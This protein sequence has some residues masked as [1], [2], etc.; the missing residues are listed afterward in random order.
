MNQLNLQSLKVNYSN[1]EVY[2][3]DYFVDKSSLQ[4][5][6]KDAYRTDLNK[7]RFKEFYLP[8]LGQDIHDKLSFQDPSVSTDI[9]ADKHTVISPIYGCHDNCCIYLFAKVSRYKDQVFW[10][11]IGKNK[12]YMT[13]AVSEENIQW[14]PHFSPLVFTLKDYQNI[15]KQLNSNP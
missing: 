8:I 15:I 11:A 1:T 7:G 13:Q 6:L 5:Q 10:K 2:I 9:P 4:N 14:L 12:T 3:S